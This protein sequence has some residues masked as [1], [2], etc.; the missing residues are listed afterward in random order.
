MSEWFTNELSEHGSEPGCLTLEG[1]LSLPWDYYAPLGYLVSSLETGT[2]PGTQEG[3]CASDY[4][5]KFLRKTKDSV[6]KATTT[7]VFHQC[8]NWDGHNPLCR[9]WVRIL[10]LNLKMEHSTF[11]HNDELKEKCSVWLEHKA[12]K[13]DGLH[14]NVF[15]LRPVTAA[16]GIWKELFGPCCFMEQKPIRMGDAL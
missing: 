5:K 9:I 6:S 12:F 1:F 10:C 2:W 16:F 11:W 7:L 14:K 4:H 15:A 8:S 13:M 3:L